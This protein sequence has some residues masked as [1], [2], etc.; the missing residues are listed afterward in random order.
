MLL[1]KVGLGWTLRIWALST[2]LFSG[3]ALL[4]MRNRLPVPKFTAL[5]RRP[6]FIPPHIGFV[7]NPLFWTFV[8]GCST[9]SLRYRHLPRGSPQAITNMLQGL[10]YFPVS[11]YIATFTRNVANQLTATIVLAL[12]N[13]SAVVGQIIMGHLSDR[14][15]YPS[16]MVFSAVGSALSAFFLWGFA[17]AAIFLYFFAVI[18]GGLV[19]AFYLREKYSTYPTY[20]RAGA[21]RLPGRTRLSSPSGARSSTPACPSRAPRSS[22]ASR[23]SSGLSFQVSC[24]RAGT[25]HLWVA[26]S[27]SLG[28]A[29]SRSSSGLVLLRLGR[30]AWRLHSRVGGCNLDLPHTY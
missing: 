10:S 5:N 3:I 24:C 18:F 29:R 21:S 14:F 13:S 8:S 26:G 16:I 20:L 25:V 6:R 19:S 15:P 1:D 30:G 11:L 9:A 7:R 17:D 12:F 4:G 28:T 27:A 23:L 2:S 22:R